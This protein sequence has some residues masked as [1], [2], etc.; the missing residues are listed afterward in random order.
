MKKI[1]SIILV[2]VMI[3]S[4]TAL[5]SCGEKNVKLGLGVS[6]SGLT[7]TN[8]NGD[9]DGAGKVTINVAAVTVDA[10]GKIVACDID[11]LDATVKYTSTGT[12][13]ASDLKTKRELGNDYNMVA[14][15]KASAEWYVQA[16]KFESVVAG[17]TIDEVKALVVADTNKGTDE[18][19]K[20]G[21][22]ITIDAFV[23]AIEK[24]CANATDSD[25]TTESAVKLGTFVEQKCTNA[26][27][28]KDGS[29]QLDVTFFASATDADGKIVAAETDCAQIK[30]TFDATGKSTLDTTK[31]IST[32]REQGDKYGMVAY[33]GGKVTK[34]WFE[35]ADIFEAQVI[36]KTAS[37]VSALMGT[38]NYGTADVK[39]AGCTIL[40][41]GFVKAAA[42][43]AK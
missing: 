6:I 20:A 15:G 43:T 29:N 17:K 22:T 37:D 14:Y 39:S 42:K 18:V 24:A 38:D 4:V 7:A 13:T 28:D 1:T 41:N 32:K 10:D 31:T 25:A 26:T 5:V 16:D 11:T 23:N 36:G 34:E 12:T 21:C 40:V 2:L 9:T 3:F 19:V 8:A 35:Q 27:A 33:G 30:F